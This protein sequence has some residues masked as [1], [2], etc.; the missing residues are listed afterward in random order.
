MPNAPGVLPVPSSPNLEVFFPAPRNA[1]K[2]DGAGLL[3]PLRK[4]N[5][6]RRCVTRRPRKSRP[7][8]RGAVLSVLINTY[9][10]EITLVLG[11][12]DARYVHIPCTGGSEFFVRQWLP[13]LAFM[14]PKVRSRPPCFSQSAEVTPKG[15]LPVAQI[16]EC[17]AAAILSPR[18]LFR[19][20]SSPFVSKPKLVVSGGQ[21]RT[22]I[23]PTVRN[24][25]PN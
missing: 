4:R 24:L 18:A 20:A 6:G 5:R 25:E 13:M 10:V 2:P 8:G 23:A 16:P 9:K 1:E 21:S 22:S 14:V 17:L 7:Y 11:V 15:A 19:L 3:K 12:E